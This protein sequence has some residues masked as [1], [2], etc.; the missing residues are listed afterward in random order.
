VYPVNDCEPALGFAVI[1]R[2]YAYGSASV[3]ALTHNGD[4]SGASRMVCR[5]GGE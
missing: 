1:D 3:A 2:V 5:Y 4:G